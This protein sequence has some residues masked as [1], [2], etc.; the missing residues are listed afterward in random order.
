MSELT[1]VM[2]NHAM[3]DATPLRYGV[4]PP[5]YVVLK[6]LKLDQDST[7]DQKPKEIRKGNKHIIADCYTE[8]TDEL[9]FTARFVIGE[10][11]NHSLYKSVITV[12]SLEQDKSERAV[13]DLIKSLRESGKI[14]ADF[15]KDKLHPKYVSG[16]IKGNVDFYNYLVQLG[17]Q[18][19]VKDLE[20][21]IDELQRDSDLKQDKLDEAEKKN[22]AYRQKII[23][24]EKG[25]P[26]YKGEDVSVSP[27][28]T[29]KDVVEGSRTKRNGQKV[30]CTTLI[31][32]EPVPQRV[33]DEIFDKNGNITKKAKG[34]INCK[35]QTTSWKPEVF[36]PI[37]WFRDIYPVID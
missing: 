23:D 21:Y 12:L 35:V 1:V 17:I 10:P 8:D 24:L 28:C 6:N 15:I 5:K 11:R 13:S 34:L 31:F 3:N 19:Q 27:V 32:E 9:L 14:D 29:L 25:K 4:V 30:R 18:D 20:M 2:T 7:N 26:M 36:K 33:M 16:E 37:D 22:E